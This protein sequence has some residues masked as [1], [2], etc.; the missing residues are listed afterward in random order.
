MSTLVIS[1]INFKTKAK[2]VKAIR[3]NHLTTLQEVTNYTKAGGAC[4]SCHEKIEEIIELIRQ[5]LYSKNNQKIAD[6]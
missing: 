4:G 6:E 1:E 5:Y 2:I 3:E